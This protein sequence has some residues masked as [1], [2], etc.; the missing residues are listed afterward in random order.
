MPALTTLVFV[1]KLVVL[2]FG[3]L[4]VRSGYR[5]YRRTG[6]TALRSLTLGFG[7]VTL[8][9]VLGGGAHQLL[10]VGLETGVLLES[11]LMAAGFGVLAHALFV[12]DRRPAADE[13]PLV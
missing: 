10:G 4:I 6:S 3:A 2:A 9:G 7:L 8:G 13:G 5:A 12:V 11:V 1:A